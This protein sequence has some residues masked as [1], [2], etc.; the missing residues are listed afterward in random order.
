MEK[1]LF[2]YGQTLPGTLSVGFVSEKCLKEN[3]REKISPHTAVCENCSVP[4]AAAQLG[5]WGTEGFP[6]DRVALRGQQD[7]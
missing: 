5:S 2:S 7:S 3:M 1:C 6:G 4:E